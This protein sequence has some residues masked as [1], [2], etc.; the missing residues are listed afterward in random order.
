MQLFPS[1]KE[2][3]SQLPHSAHCSASTQETK[4]RGR[5]GWEERGRSEQLHLCVDKPHD[6][7]TVQKRGKESLISLL[8]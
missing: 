7:C 5:E 8:Y 2:R 1:E 6:Y 3:A 4:G